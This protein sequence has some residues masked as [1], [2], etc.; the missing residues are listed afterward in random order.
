LHSLGFFLAFGTMTA[1][2]FVLARHFGA[3]GQRGWR[4]YS[5]ATGVAAPLLV[6]LGMASV[7]ATG[8]GFALSAVVVTWW[9]AAIAARL[10]DEA[11]PAIEAR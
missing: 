1:A 6:V 8:V 5:I 2:C 10:V 4:A 3:S 11:S 7:I 9:A